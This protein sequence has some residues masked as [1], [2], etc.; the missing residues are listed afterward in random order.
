MREKMLRQ[1]EKFMKEAHRRQEE[2]KKLKIEA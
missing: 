2:R 1:N